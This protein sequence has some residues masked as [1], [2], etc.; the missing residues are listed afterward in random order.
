MGAHL[1]WL[2]MAVL[3][4]GLGAVGTMGTITSAPCWAAPAPS[5]T[6]S[7]SATTTRRAKAKFEEGL[8]LSDE[9]KWAEALEAFKASDELAAS[10]TVRFNIAVTLRALGRYV[11]ARDVGRSIL[12]DDAEKVRPI[13]PGL[14]ADVQKLVNEVAAKVALVVLEV[15]PKDATLQVDDAAPT[16]DSQGRLETDPGRHVFILTA[17]GYETTTVTKEILPGEQELVLVAP[18]LPKAKPAVGPRAGGSLEEETP[19]YEGGVFWGITVSV[20]VAGAA[21]A[22]LA[23][24]LQ[25][26][27]VEPASPPTS[28]LGYEIPVALRVRF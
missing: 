16:L 10:A 7:A 15:T 5:A 12:D 3:L 17:P 21:A 28:T 23:V 19:W 2:P 27:E 14:K 6:G 25:P 18:P 1:R 11:E 24:V 22:I 9:G 13:K 4:C 26:D 8:A 20:V